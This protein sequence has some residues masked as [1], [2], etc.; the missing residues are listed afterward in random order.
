M[1]SHRSMNRR[2]P[3][4]PT[5]WNEHRTLQVYQMALL[6]ATNAQM[7]DMMQVSVK[8]LEYWIR[9]K[10]E[11]RERLM[12]GRA[13]ADARVAESLY[14]AAVGY[15]YEEDVVTNCRG[16][17]TV[18]RVTKHQPGNPWAMWKWLTARQRIL[19]SDTQ[20][21]REIHNTLNI[22][23]IDMSELTTAELTL[24]RKLNQ[25]F[26]KQIPESL[27]DDDQK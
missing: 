8:T 15:D 25:K 23:N 5:Q 7:A 10:P 3:L 18:T 27:D 19:W 20:Q 14:K 2:L 24:L 6:G 13:P 11:F 9:T 12:E 26:N 4:R 21:A 16:V 22:N 17:V 1:Q